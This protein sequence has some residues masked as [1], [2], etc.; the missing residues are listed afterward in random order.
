[1]QAQLGI[2]NQI[3]EIDHKEEIVIGDKSIK[4]FHTP[5]HAVH[6]IAWQTDE[7]IIC[8]DVAGIGIDHGPAMPPCPPPDINFEHWKSSIDILL[9]ENPK[10][11]FIAH[12]GVHE[13]GVEHLTSLKKEI[14]IWDAYVSELYL[15]ESDPRKAIGQFEEW[16][17]QRVVD[18]GATAELKP[19]YLIANPAWISIFGLFRYYSKMKA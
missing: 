2:K 14:D 17:E 5:G 8:G 13:N 16:L 11:L 9:A 12:F 10:T 4:S 15:R 1:M 7:G 19:L 3:I 18:A 6:H